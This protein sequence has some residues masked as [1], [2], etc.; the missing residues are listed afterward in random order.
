L[1]EVREWHVRKI[2]RTI[3][4]LSVKVGGNILMLQNPFAVEVPYSGVRIDFMFDN[5]NDAH[6]DIR[7]HV[8]IDEDAA[9]FHGHAVGRRHKYAPTSLLSRIE[10]CFAV[11]WRHRHRWI[12]AV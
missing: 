5:E 11:L 7:E 6:R 12:G 9:W 4:R 1:A 2:A 3:A 8:D 10:G